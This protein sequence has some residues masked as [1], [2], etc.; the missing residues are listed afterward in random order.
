[1]ALAELN[2]YSMAPTVPMSYA[3][4]WALIRNMREVM[5]QTPDFELKK[6]H[7]ELL[8]AGSVALPLVFQSCFGEAASKLACEKLV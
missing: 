3:T 2:W 6:F 8:S 1:Q 4:G 7:D 5:Q